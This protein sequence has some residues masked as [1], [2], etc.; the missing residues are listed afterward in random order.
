MSGKL[1][2]VTALLAM[3]FAHPEETPASAFSALA[4]AFMPGQHDFNF[5]LK[6]DYVKKLIRNAGGP[7][8]PCIPPAVCKPPTK[9]AVPKS[10]TVEM[11]STLLRS[12]STSQPDHAPKWVFK[13]NY[14]II[15]Y[16]AFPLT[17]NA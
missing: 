9:P 15:S 10:A 13:S 14:E 4:A 8:T 11:P 5:G 17:L 2:V 16:D 7:S 6:D 1:F 12:L 3:A